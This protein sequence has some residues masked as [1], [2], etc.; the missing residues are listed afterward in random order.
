VRRSGSAPCSRD[1]SSAPPTAPTNSVTPRRPAGEPSHTDGGR[2]APPT[3]PLEAVRLGHRTVVQGLVEHVLG[4]PA[5]PGDLS[6]G[7]AGGCRLLD[8]LARGVVAD[9]GVEGRGGR[10]RQLRIT[11][12][13]LPVRLDPVYA[14]L[15]EQTGR[16]REE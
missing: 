16:G 6:Q 1:R 7:P 15:G 14:L 10:E 2:E 8:D 3:L 5:L 12:A 13:H 9:V 11:L 4:D